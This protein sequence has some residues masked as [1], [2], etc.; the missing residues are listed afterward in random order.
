MKGFK[1]ISEF[2]RIDVVINFLIIFFLG[3]SLATMMIIT[4]RNRE[5]HVELSAQYNLQQD[6]LTTFGSYLSKE[7][8]AKEEALA[9]ANRKK[10]LDESF[11]QAQEMA[12]E[13]ENVLLTISDTGI[14]IAEENLKRIFM[15]D[16]R[17]AQNRHCFSLHCSADFCMCELTKSHV[18]TTYCQ[19]EIYGRST[20]RAW[21]RFGRSV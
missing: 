17:N 13:A 12:K 6:T 14:G 7:L 20:K 5:K 21:K 8:S 10:M 16:Y 4:I 9:V 19:G 2:R 1:R 11:A 15:H 18:Q 3:A